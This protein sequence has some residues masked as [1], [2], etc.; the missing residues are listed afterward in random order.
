[1]KIRL[2]SVIVAIALLSATQLGSPTQAAASVVPE[3][4]T[5]VPIS[6]S[7]SSACGFVANLPIEVGEFITAGIPDCDWVQIAASLFASAECVAAF[8]GMVLLINTGLGGFLLH[9]AIKAME[10]ACIGALVMISITLANCLEDYAS[11]SPPL[12]ER[13]IFAPSPLEGVAE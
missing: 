12:I 6:I 11:A 2:A 8:A 13:S 5:S 1:M 4:S 3:V 10:A 7:T 9:L